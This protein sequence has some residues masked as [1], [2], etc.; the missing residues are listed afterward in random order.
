MQVASIASGLTTIFQ[1]GTYYQQTTLP[2]DM[3]I[4]TMSCPTQRII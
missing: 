4:S 3:T 2:A 1:N